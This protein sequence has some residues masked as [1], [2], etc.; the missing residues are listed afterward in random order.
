MVG[1]SKHKAQEKVVSG[2]HE[3]SLCIDKLAQ[4]C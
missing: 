1:N 2:T 3:P 4:G